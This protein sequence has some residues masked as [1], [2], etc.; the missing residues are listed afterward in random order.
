V[1]DA[2]ARGRAGGKVILL[3]EHVV[4]YG[5]PAVA[6]GL[7]I[8]L[9]AE[10]LRGDGP[11]LV[12]DLGA[13]PRGAELVA[14]AARLVGLAPHDW[15]VR[16]HSEIP[17]GQGLGSSAALCVAVLRALAAAAGRG[18]R[19]DEEIARGRLLEGIFHGTP[20]GIDPAAAI[21]A[22][23]FRFVRGEPPS[24]EPVAVA[25]P[26]P[27]VI[28]LAASA[29][30]TGSAVGGL[31]ARWEADPARH[32][33][34]FDA[35]AAVV[36]DGVDALARGDLAALGRAFDRNQA[37]LAELGVSSPDVERR[38][39]AARLA[40]ALGAKLTGGGAGGA[41][42]ALVDASCRA[43]VARALEGSG[44][45]PLDVVLRGRP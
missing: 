31:R 12:G 34:M 38:V 6:S 39:A 41:V 35:V 13:D 10:A 42:I 19:A 30:S 21:V 25:A 1:T 20:S 18:F 23:P 22:A 45:R 24:I 44:A 37:L 17:A 7:P 11:A 29:R 36:D 14:A 4:V 5:R 9:E 40:G 16:V 28:G 3:G 33:A 26:V 27:L 2:P 8:G 32:E 43:A 15:T